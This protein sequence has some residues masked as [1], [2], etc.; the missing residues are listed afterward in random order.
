MRHLFRSHKW[1][2]HYCILQNKSFDEALTLAAKHHLEAAT[3]TLS[4]HKRR[5]CTEANY[6]KALVEYVVCRDVPFSIAESEE[7]GKLG[8]TMN[9]QVSCSEE[10]FTF[11]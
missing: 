3:S 11:L 1:E 7:F 8:Q 4:G 2:H 9:D 5:A 6:R 10:N